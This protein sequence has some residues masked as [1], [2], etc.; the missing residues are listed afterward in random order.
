MVRAFYQEVVNDIIRDTVFEP[1][2][3]E[4]SMR[5]VCRT[6]KKLKTKDDASFEATVEVYPEVEV[7]D[8]ADLKLSANFRNQRLMLM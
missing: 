2:Q 6:L 7:K 4:K 5:S 8:F 3:Q 1:I